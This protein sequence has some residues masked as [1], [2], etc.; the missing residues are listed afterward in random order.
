M[1][2]DILERLADLIRPALA[3]RP[4]STGPKPAG[5][6][7][8]TGFTVTQAMTSLTGSS[9]EDFASILRGARL[10]HGEAARSL[11]S[12][13]RSRRQLQRQAA[14]DAD[15]TEPTE[16]VV[17][18]QSS[19]TLSRDGDRRGGS[20]GRVEADRGDGTDAAAPAVE[21]GT[22]SDLR[23]RAKTAE[24]DGSRPRQDA[25]ALAAESDAWRRDRA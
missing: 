4:N 13:R 17:H 21:D 22:E 20:A 9:G 8:G 12:R 10:S 14:T 16:A 1:R 23:P 19:R 24:P 15:A 3:W 2:V 11:P 25:V 7:E 5:A 18:R 6:F